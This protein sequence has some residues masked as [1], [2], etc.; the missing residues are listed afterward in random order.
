M[1]KSSDDPAPID[2]ASSLAEAPEFRV[3]G[4]LPERVAP[5]VPTAVPGADTCR[6][7]FPRMESDR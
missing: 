3:S 5:L 4:G 1:K 7:R 2:T 6:S